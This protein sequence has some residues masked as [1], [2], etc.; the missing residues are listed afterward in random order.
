MLNNT[1]HED[2]MPHSVAVPTP[3]ASDLRREP[4][5]PVLHGA[6]RDDGVRN[7]Q[8]VLHPLARSGDEFLRR[9]R[10]GIVSCPSRGSG[11]DFRHLLLPGVAFRRAVRHVG[12][13][14]FVD[15]AE[16]RAGAGIHREEGD[17]KEQKDNQSSHASHHGAHL[18]PFDV[19]HL[20]ALN[21]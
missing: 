17:G 4:I 21:Y 3:A 19:D 11:G 6:D 9:A 13:S 15:P 14:F 1:P 10:A 12:D 5:G 7:K 20:P 2:A 8:G 18:F 16:Q